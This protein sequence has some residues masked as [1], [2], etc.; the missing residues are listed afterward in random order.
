MRR[1]GDWFLMTVKRL[2]E[3][4][5]LRCTYRGQVDYGIVVK[6]EAKTLDVL[7]VSGSKTWP[8]TGH[9]FVWINRSDD[10][11]SGRDWEMGDDLAEMS[12]S[13]VS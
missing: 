11:L 12:A 5:R 6:V 1:D 10:R 2:R 8:R 7:F 4:D 13:R 3:D 9:V